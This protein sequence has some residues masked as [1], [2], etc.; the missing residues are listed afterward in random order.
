[1]TKI[2][3]GK[4]IIELNN[5]LLENG[6][7]LDKGTYKKTT[8]DN[9]K[10]KIDTRENNLKIYVNSIKILSVP[11]VKIQITALKTYLQKHNF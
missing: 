11:L 2:Q 6:F 10:I 4:H 7:I 5:V 8:T 1:M 9:R 3:R